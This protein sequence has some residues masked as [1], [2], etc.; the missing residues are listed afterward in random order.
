[1]GCYS[2]EHSAIYQQSPRQSYRATYVLSSI[3]L[4]MYLTALVTRCQRRQTPGCYHSL[5]Y[6]RFSSSPGTVPVARHGNHRQFENMRLFSD[7]GRHLPHGCPLHRVS[8]TALFLCVCVLRTLR[9]FF[10]N[11]YRTSHTVLLGSISD[12]NPSAGHVRVNVVQAIKHAAYDDV[13][14]T[15]DIAI[16][17]LATCV[18]LTRRLIKQFS[19]YR[20]LTPFR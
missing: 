8:S 10:C 3:C 5:D 20:T 13:K 4:K 9:C 2:K 1:M 7:Q 17:K 16:L 18:N 19:L 14:I 15:N 11:L 12:D 6:W